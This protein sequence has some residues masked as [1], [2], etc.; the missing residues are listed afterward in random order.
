MVHRAVGG[1]ELVGS[2]RGDARR[3]EGSIGKPEEG[4]RVAVP[5]VEEEVL[6]SVVGQLERLRQGHPEH[7]AIELDGLRHV[8]ADQRQVIHPAQ[9]EL[10]VLILGHA[11]TSASPE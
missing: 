4:Q 1:R 10:L 9:L 6:A 3:S 5:A 8:L 7:V 11:V 2:W